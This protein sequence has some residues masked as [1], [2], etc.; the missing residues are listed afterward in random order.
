MRVVAPHEAVRR[1]TGRARIDCKERSGPPTGWLS[2]LPLP[3]PTVSASQHILARPIESLKPL[4]TSA[5]R[6]LAAW[7]LIAAGALKVVPQPVSLF[8]GFGK[9]C[10]SLSSSR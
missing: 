6:L 8:R 9:C 10:L 2:A 1:Q 7:A 3:S 4:S 5:L